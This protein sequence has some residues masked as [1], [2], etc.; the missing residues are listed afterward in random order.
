MLYSS[1]TRLPEELKLRPFVKLIKLKIKSIKTNKI[2]WNIK[3][4]LE[5]NIFIDIVPKSTT[6]VPKYNIHILIVLPTLRVTPK[7]SR[8]LI[9]MVSTRKK[10]QYFLLFCFCRWTFFYSLY[11]SLYKT[12]N[13]NN[14]SVIMCCWFS[15]SWITFMVIL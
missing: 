13:I 6:Q 10:K 14:Q 11:F 5:F 8:F 3:N 2:K 12:C 15:E 7:V 4:K 9:Y 1:N